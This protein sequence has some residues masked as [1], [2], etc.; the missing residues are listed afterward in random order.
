MTHVPTSSLAAQLGLL[1]AER[2]ARRQEGVATFRQLYDA[3]VPRW[4]VRRELRVRRWARHGQQVV[5]TH[6]GPLGGPARRWWAVLELGPRAALAGVSALQHDGVTALT[7]TDIHVIVPRGA[8]RPRLAGVVVHESRRWREADI[9]TSGLRRTVPAVSA[10]HAGLWA[11][12]EKQ[13][14]FLLLLAV[15]QQLCEPADLAEVLSTVRR[16]RWRPALLDTTAEL[17]GGARSLGEVD[18]ARAMRARGLPEPTRQ[19]LRRRP[20]GNEYLDADFEDY[21]VALEVDGAQHDLP[22]ARLADTVRDI[23]LAT[24]G[25]AVVRIP[26]VAWRLGREQVLDALEAL[27]TARGWS[28][29][30]A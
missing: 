29:P 12:T 27:F 25:R 10:V 6:N 24:E 8:R 16:H 3:G 19:A 11:V 23:A 2:L 15:Q 26:L 5:A 17:V 14:T 21:D 28:R 20:S 18:V 7:D 1:R 9:A 13:A 4:L 30:A 22:W